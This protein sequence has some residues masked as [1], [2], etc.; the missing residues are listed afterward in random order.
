MGC[1]VCGHF[2]CSSVAG[3]FSRT[4]LYVE[5][6]D[7]L[8]LGGILIGFEKLLGLWSCYRFGRRSSTTPPPPFFLFACR[9]ARGQEQTSTN[10]VGHRRGPSRELPSAS[11]LVSSMSTKQLRFFYR[12]PDSISLE[13]S[14]GSSI[15]TVGEV[16]NAVYFTRKEFAVGLCFPAS[17]LVKQFLH[18][19]R[20][21]PAL[22]HLNVIR[23]LTG[24]SVLNLLYRLDI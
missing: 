22:I 24:C 18:V 19:S 11:N 8:K 4:E 2:T 20:A 10:Q 23:I 12:V 21:P 17:S 14:D 6:W 13:L 15:S 16:D 5:F 9:M 1:L 3:R 7:A